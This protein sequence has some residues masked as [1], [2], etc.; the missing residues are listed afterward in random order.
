MGYFFDF[1]KKL[2]HDVRNGMKDVVVQWNP[3]FATELEIEQMEKEFDKINAELTRAK[4]EM[5]REVFEYNEKLYRYKQLLASAKLLQE[6]GKAD[7]AVLQM[8]KAEEMVADM[9]KEKAEAEEATDYFVTLQKELTDFAGKITSAKQEIESKRRQAQMATLKA[10]R[11]DRKVEHARLLAGLKERTSGMASLAQ[12]YDK[13]RE[14]AEQKAESSKRKA[15]VFTSV[16]P[17]SAKQE[18]DPDI[19][20]A[21]AAA[22]GKT[23]PPSSETFEERMARLSKIG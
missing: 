11:E 14:E 18:E 20:A 17:P 7:K 13:Q 1:G 15:E 9:D 4:Q 23:A 22:A 5:D 19:T 16:A 10:E 12:I 6:Q 21:M 3:E 2:F 8:N